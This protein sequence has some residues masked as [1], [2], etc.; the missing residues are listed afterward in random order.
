MEEPNTAPASGPALGG[1][2]LVQASLLETGTNKRW[3]WWLHFLVI[4]LYPLLIGLVG[5]GKAPKDVPALG[6]NARFLLVTCGVE[7]VFFGILLGLALWASRASADFLLLRWRSGFWPVPQGIG[8]SVALRLAL[9]VAIGG[10]ALIL[11]LARVISIGALQDFFVNNRPDVE[12]VVDLSAL[13]NNPVYFWLTLTLVSFVVAGLREE[14]WRSAFLAGARGLWPRRFTSRKGQFMAAAMAAVIFGLGH[15]PQGPIAV[16]LTA[17]LG[18][19]L[20]AIM[21]YHQSIWPAVIAH[22]MFDAT[23]LA[24]LPWALENIKDFQK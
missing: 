4:G 14:L 12:A 7:L 23:S 10:L 6:E 8:Y 11:V 5:L 15:A 21:I 18:L 17:L 19:G 2:P 16:C 9:G 20:G 22:G 1:P 24:A 3:R 13:R